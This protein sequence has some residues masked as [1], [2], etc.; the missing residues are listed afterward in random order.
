MEAARELTAGAVQKMPAGDFFDLPPRRT[1]VVMVDFQ[2]DFCSPQV[3][4]PGPVTNTHN[5][6]AAQRGNVFAGQA[7]D[8]G[9]HVLYT[10]QVLDLSR[11]T[12]RQ[13]RWERHDGLCAAGTWGAELFVEPVR[14]ARVVVKHRFDCWQSPSFTGF[15]DRNDIDGLVICGVELV[16]CVLYAVLGAAERGYHYVVPQD[17]VSGQNPGDEADNKAVRDYLRLNRPEHTIESSGEILTRWRAQ[18]GFPS[19]TN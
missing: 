12:E 17:L 7:T 3:C 19:G 13:R 16:C 1:A 10:Q 8:L 2:N 15:L 9:A 14:G 11:L 6:E 18:A 4:S 5:A